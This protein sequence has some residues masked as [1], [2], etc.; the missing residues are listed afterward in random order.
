VLEDRL[1]LSID[2][3]VSSYGNDSVM[4]YNGTTGAFLGA[5]VIPGY[6]GLYGPHGLAIG[7]D[8]NLLVSSDDSHA[9]LGYNS[10]TGAFMG[11]FVPPGSDGL[12][13][14]HGIA[15][16][17]DNNLYVSGQ[18][19]GNILRYNGTTGAFMGVF[20]PPGSGGLDTPSGILF[21]PDGNLYVNSFNNSSVMRYDGTTGDPLPASGQSG[22]FFVTP[23]SG[24]LDHTSMAITFGPDG[25]LY[26]GGYFSHNVV[27]Y[28]G[29]TG[30]FID[31]FVF[32]GSGGL[33]QTQGL[34]FGP[35]GN[36]YV[37]SNANSQVLRYD[38]AT[39][40]FIDAF[41]PPGGPLNAPTYLFFWDTGGDSPHGH[42]GG[43]THHVTASGAHA[44][45]LADVAVLVGLGSLSQPRRSGNAP[46]IAPAS[47]GDW[48]VT[49]E[50][51]A[52]TIS[53]IAA[54]PVAPAMPR[55]LVA[56]S[57]GRDAADMLF[58]AWPTEYTPLEPLAWWG[59]SEGD[60]R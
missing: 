54:G 10:I 53:A 49:A 6:G 26:V 25:N 50:M 36:L 31:T 1:C 41:V 28:D 29:T 15:F 46:E 32:A 16:G 56:P 24:G 33:S 39:G 58:R 3:L 60:L 30:A 12:S 17:P 42:G 47:S 27:R 9:V 13:N 59:N 45:G 57:L 52:P 23:G 19:S 21:G 18:I 34:A 11:A 44:A 20:V 35:D 14:P 4:R 5:F 2:L 51:H 37:C 22:A 8:G 38:G 48:P 7:L 43:A 55:A 40:T